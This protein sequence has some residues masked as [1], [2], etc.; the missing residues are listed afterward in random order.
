MRLLALA[1]FL[2]AP[3]RAQDT[4][5]ATQTN[6]SGS[7]QAPAGQD[8]PKKTRVEQIQEIGAKP[9][10][11]PVKYPPRM[12]KNLNGMSNEEF[13]AVTKV[14][15]RNAQPDQQVSPQ[16]LGFAMH[17][18]MKN[19]DGGSWVKKWFNEGGDDGDGKGNMPGWHGRRHGGGSSEPSTDGL[20]EAKVDPGVYRSVGPSNHAYGDAQTGL[21]V[22]AQMRGDNRAAYS[23]YQNAVNSGNNDARTLTFGSLAAL[24]AGDPKNAYNWSAT[25]LQADPGGALAEQ[26]TAVNRMAIK[27]LPK[28]EDPKAPI[29]GSDPGEPSPAAARSPA[30]ANAAAAAGSI[31]E[32][33][34]PL[35]PRAATAGLPPEA[36][37]VVADTNRLMALASKAYRAGDM[38]EAVKLSAETLAKDPDDVR[39]LQVSAAAHAKE[40]KWDEV[41]KEADRGLDLAPGYVPLLLLRSAS[42]IHVKDWRSAKAD[43]AAVLSKEKAN[44]T[45]WRFMGIAQS[46]LGER[47]ESVTSLSR[48]VQYGDPEARRLLA[49][50]RSL[51]PGADAADLVEM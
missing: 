42:S 41:R 3:A 40:G 33:E 7:G 20:P 22:Q 8:P 16:S 47:E 44:P 25:A 37:A 15:A 43:A 38:K 13:E 39:A 48:A 6:D 32:L 46:G 27:R 1:L 35:Q 50:A 26:A 21:G 18:A 51:P 29:R 49:L 12:Q 9:G 31:P 10:V 5:A 30:P 28:E 19:S 14:I 4:T 23:H 36:L 11:D 17:A 34:R 45:A 2:A 24:N